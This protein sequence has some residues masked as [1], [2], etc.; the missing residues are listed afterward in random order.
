MIRN[1]LVYKVI[2]DYKFV[3]EWRVSLVVILGMRV[4]GWGNIRVKVFNL[5]FDW[6]G[7]GIVRGFRVE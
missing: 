4:L 6:Y 3:G 2:F 5:E 1:V 7:E